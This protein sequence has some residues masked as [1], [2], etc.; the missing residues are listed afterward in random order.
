[1]QIMKPLFV[2]LIFL[3]FPIDSYT[4]TSIRFYGNGVNAPDQDRIK[5]QIDD[6][7]N[8]DPG[9]P[10]DV[11]AS[12]FT[13]EFWLK[14][15]LTD[16]NASSISCGNNNNWI[17]G[18]IVIDRDRFNQGRNYGVSI[19]GGYLVFGVMN[20]FSQAQT[21]CGTTIVLD[22]DWHHVALQRRRSDGFMELYVDG[23]LEASGDGPD[24]DI[25]YPDDGIP[26]LNCCGG[27]C[28]FSDPFIVLGA[29]KHDAGAQYPSYNG[30]LD[31]LRY[32][33][34]RR[35]TTNFTAY[36]QPF[37]TDMHTVGLYHFDEGNGTTAFDSSNAN[38]G[39]S[40]GILQVG[41]TPQGPLWTMDSPF[42]ITNSDTITI[43][44]IGNSITQAENQG[45]NQYNSWRRQL[46]QELSELAQPAVIDFIG[47]LNVA[48]PGVPFP[49]NDFDPDHEGHWGWRIDEIVDNLGGWLTTVGAPHMAL[50]HLGSND[51]FQGQSINSSVQELEQVIDT[52]RKF[53][54]KMVI[55]LAQII[56]SSFGD[57]LCI[58]ELNDSIERIA[59][60]KH[61]E[62][63]P[64]E[65]VD[66]NT[67][68]SARTDTYDN[69]HPNEQG[70]AKMANQWYA[71]IAPFIS[72]ATTTDI[73]LGQNDLQFYP[74]PTSGIFE[75]RGDLGKYDLDI[76]DVNGTVQETVDNSVH[77][78]VIDISHL[79]AGLFFIRI[80]H[81]INGALWV[82]VLLK[83][84]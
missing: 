21:I 7:A 32:S 26:C 41:G 77:A 63:S 45:G 74:N 9:P 79:P 75:I 78:E 80:R 42:S 40:N 29:E 50:L 5:I 14:G 47:S 59:I 30:L 68:F 28:N 65:L 37:V 64:I 33:T 1:M 36:K 4:Q 48:F 84:M 16:N 10:V 23:I 11:G 3:L 73:Y 49:D 17:N 15:S 6:I 57:S 52:L 39:P 2:S 62:D 51:C 71:A 20:E 81:K 72:A 83:T 70:E 24:G 82:E 25:S 58:E 27:P 61:T 56:P 12:D 53:N 31:E 76:L 19:A 60:R 55:F 46:Y 44:P 13:I 43:M 22:N 69:I 66:Q 18:N 38:G 67:G 8:N 54:D 34:M 35:Y